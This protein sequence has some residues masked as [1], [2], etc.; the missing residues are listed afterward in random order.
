MM[1]ILQGADMVIHMGAFVD[2]G[3]KPG[4][5]LTGGFAL[6]PGRGCVQRE[7]PLHANHLEIRPAVTVIIPAPKNSILR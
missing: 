2:E 1:R 4:V 3:P 6:I 5:C 7:G